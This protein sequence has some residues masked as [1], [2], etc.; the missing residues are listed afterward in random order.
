MHMDHSNTHAVVCSGLVK[1]FNDSHPD[2]KATP[3]FTGSPPRSSR[4]GTLSFSVS[5][6]RSV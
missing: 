5:N 4:T 6:R 1:E 3:V 2:I